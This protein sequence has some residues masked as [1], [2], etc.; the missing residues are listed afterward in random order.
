MRTAMLMVAGLLTGAAALAMPPSRAPQPDDGVDRGPDIV[1]LDQ[2]PG[3]Y[4]SVRFD[5]RLHVG[6]SDI[7]TGCT[8]CHHTEAIQPCRDCH[9]PRPGAI[10]K[11]VLG[12][13][14]AYHAQCLGCHKDWA[15]ENACGFCHTSSSTSAEI[16]M[17]VAHDAH[18]TRAIAN[19]T[20]TYQTAKQGL[21]VVT[22]HHAD[23]TDVFGIDCASCHVGTSCGQ[24][25]GPETQRPVVNRHQ[26]C[27]RCHADSEC[28]LCHSLVEKPR[29]DHTNC[30]NWRL[31]PG[32]YGLACSSCHGET[33]MPHRPDSKGCNTCHGA[34]TAGVFDHASTGVMLY[35]DHALFQ[36]VDCHAG[37]D[38]T[39]L[40]SCEGC[41][42]QREIIGFRS[43]GTPPDQKPAAP[44]APEP[45]AEPDAR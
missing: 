33:V 13:R 30:G 38:K 5:H 11:D 6:M 34:D 3:C 18:L 20:Y 43:V 29:F 2:V 24:C 44:P 36:C 1:D 14:G 42:E 17:P 25:H 32:H 28:V 31:R 23:H 8:V 21:P 12:L 41:H 37:R 15:H 22:F 16:P 4:G 9:D 45:E 35:G 27:Y 39:K 26:S 10:T 19:T 40:A 7:A